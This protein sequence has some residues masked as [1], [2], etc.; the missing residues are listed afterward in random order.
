MAPPRFSKPPGQQQNGLL[1]LAQ[2]AAAAAAA[3]TELSE[4]A[5]APADA[6][7]IGGHGDN[8]RTALADRHDNMRE[9]GSYAPQP[10]NN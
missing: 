1:P 9:A 5:L 8:S 6:V 10:N 7:P 4:A 3:S 2:G